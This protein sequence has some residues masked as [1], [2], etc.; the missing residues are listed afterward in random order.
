MADEHS[1]TGAAKQ[2]TNSER[3]ESETKLLAA[4]GGSKPWWHWF[5][6]V[7]HILALVAILAGLVA[8]RYELKDIT[9]LITFQ[10]M[11]QQLSAGLA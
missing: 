3:T 9:T 8:I 11:L 1:G 6:N 2:L 5:K 7:D 10:R 4:A